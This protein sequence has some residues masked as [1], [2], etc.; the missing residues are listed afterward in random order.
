SWHH[1][2]KGKFLRGKRN[3]RLDHLINTLINE[4]LP[5]YALKQRRRDLGFEGISVEVEKR[6]DILERSKAYTK[7]DIVVL[8]DSKYLV[9]S[10]STP[11]RMYDVDIDSYTC[12]CPDYPQIS[13]C[14]H[15]CAVQQLFEDGDLP[16][17]DQQDAPASSP[18]VPSLSTLPPDDL[19]IEGVACQASSPHVPSLSTLPAQNL[20]TLPEHASHA[21]P[22]DLATIAEQLERL[23]ARFRR[24]PNRITTDALDLDS[25]QACLDDMLQ[26]TSGSSMLPPARAFAP[27]V[28]PPTARET[29]LPK[30][31]TRCAPAGDPS[32]GG[33]TTSGS[34]AKPDARGRKPTKKAKTATVPLPTIPPAATS[35]IT[36]RTQPFYLPPYPAAP[37]HQAAYSQAAYPHQ[38]GYPYYYYPVMPVS[39][40]VPP[41]SPYYRHT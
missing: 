7:E 28:K 27:V 2:L 24:G 11:S 32:Y 25:L 39:N 17:S 30:V 13:Y 29:M 31:K 20:A 26:A 41:L 12:T 36:P 9:R 38:V 21:K 14:K 16:S 5:Y 10:K 33:S 4:V 34:L 15:I 40:N 3:R 1:V 23:A 37:S 6:K 35:D 8:G 19:D 18:H 22:H